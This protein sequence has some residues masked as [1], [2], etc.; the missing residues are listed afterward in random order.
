L[1]IAIKLAFCTLSSCP[2][3]GAA[4]RRR[5]K[6]RTDSARLARYVLSFVYWCIQTRNGRRPAGRAA[7]CAPTPSCGGPFDTRAAMCCKLV[8]TLD[9]RRRWTMRPS[10]RLSR[11]RGA[12]QET[13]VANETCD[14]QNDSRRRNDESREIGCQESAVEVGRQEQRSRD[15]SRSFQDPR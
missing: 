14:C 13:V 3:V 4:I 5:T 1:E 6:F 7:G 12:S 11:G 9:L 8:C 15:V 2:S 10:G